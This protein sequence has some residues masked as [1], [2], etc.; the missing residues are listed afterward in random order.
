MSNK[1]YLVCGWTDEAWRVEVQVAD[2]GWS[3]WADWPTFTGATDAARAAQALHHYS[4]RVLAP[5]PDAG[6]V[7]WSIE[8][9][10]VE[11]PAKE[12]T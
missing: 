6:R 7:A 8:R 5:P 9:P 1:R 10:N 2:E 12:T 11:S 3:V 4:V